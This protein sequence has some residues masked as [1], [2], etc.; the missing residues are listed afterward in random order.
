MKKEQS[1]SLPFAVVGKLLNP[2]VGVVRKEDVVEL[3]KFRY[4]FFI[5]F[6]SFF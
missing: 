1:H 6:T 2:A 5:F 4:D 3:R